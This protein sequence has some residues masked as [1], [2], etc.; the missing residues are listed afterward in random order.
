M[1]WDSPCPLA[2]L[3]I[4]FIPTT[5]SSSLDCNPFPQSCIIR[6]FA[7]YSTLLCKLADGYGNPSQIYT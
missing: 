4:M 3:S 2:V 1:G 5:F 7:T 6:D